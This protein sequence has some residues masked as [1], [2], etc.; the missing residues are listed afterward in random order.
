MLKQRKEEIVSSLTDELGGV[1]T[2][3]VADPTGLTV[4]EMKEL[5]NRLRP[6]GAEFRVAKNTL[7]RPAE[8]NWSPCS[9]VRRRSRSSPAIRRPR[10]RRCPTSAARRASS[11]CAAPIWMARRWAPTA[12][13]SLRRCPRANSCWQI[14]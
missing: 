2:M 4:A 3:I 10:P 7:A 8:T 6:S 5:R 14:W 13:G 12:S 11:H 1:T 9:S